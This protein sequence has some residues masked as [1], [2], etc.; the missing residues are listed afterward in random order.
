ML[1]RK[2]TMKGDELAKQGN[3]H[4]ERF[5][6]EIIEADKVGKEGSGITRVASA[7]TR[8]TKGHIGA[9]FQ[10]VATESSG[11]SADLWLLSIP[12][13]GIP[14]NGTHNYLLR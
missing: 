13:F 4:K 14:E 9:S 1:P 3:R 12:F 11:S 8:S 10:L 2:E 7:A 5:R 6:M